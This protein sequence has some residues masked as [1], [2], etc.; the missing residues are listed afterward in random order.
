MKK[1]IIFLFKK[2]LSNKKIAIKVLINLLFLIHL[3][4]LGQIT[5]IFLLNLYLKS[6]FAVTMKILLYFLDK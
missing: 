5:L 3:F 4:D 1:I 2:F 6:E